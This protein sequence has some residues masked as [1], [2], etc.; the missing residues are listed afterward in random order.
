MQRCRTRISAPFFQISNCSFQLSPSTPQA[1]AALV[2]TRL[3]FRGYQVRN[4]PSFGRCRLGPEGGVGDPMLPTQKG[5]KVC[6]LWLQVGSAVPARSARGE[7]AFLEG[8]ASPTS[9]FWASPEQL[10]PLRAPGVRPFQPKPTGTCTAPSHFLGGS[11][12][13]Q[14]SARE[15]F[16][17]DRLRAGLI[18]G[19]GVCYPAAGCRRRKEVALTNK[20]E[21]DYY[22]PRGPVCRVQSPK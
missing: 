13:P 2:Q 21:P 15:D 9:L 1:S 8:Q 4:P 17:E 5:R 19:D 18:E 20:R 10:E 7:G 22:Q 3:W 14:S 11:P 16:C 12:R 6:L